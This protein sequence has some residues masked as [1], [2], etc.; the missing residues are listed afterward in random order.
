M[1]PKKFSGF[2]VSGYV[3]WLSELKI[4][5]LHR[6]A[7]QLDPCKADL[8]ESPL[9]SGSLTRINPCR[10]GLSAIFNPS[11]HTPNHA[12]RR[13]AGKFFGSFFQERTG[14]TASAIRYSVAPEGQH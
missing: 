4:A 5:G 8:S 9:S 13:I 10:R 3:T 7:M 11:N 14:K 1:E 2:Y 12:I 6:K